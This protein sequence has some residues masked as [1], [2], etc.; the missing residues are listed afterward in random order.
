MTPKPAL[1]LVPAPLPNP[2]QKVR[3]RVADAA[4][5]EVLVCGCGS[6]LFVP[7]AT[8]LTVMRGK[9]QGGEKRWTC[10]ACWTAGRLMVL[11]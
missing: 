9:I 3:R 4:H 6:T 8:G 2:A 11:G 5:P 1:A 10:A 7:L